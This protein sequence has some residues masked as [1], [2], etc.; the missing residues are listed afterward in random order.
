[1]G[2]LLRIEALIGSGHERRTW[3]SRHIT[4]GGL[5]SRGSCCRRSPFISHSVLFLLMR[6]EQLNT[7]L[8]ICTWIWEWEINFWLTFTPSLPTGFPLLSFCSLALLSN[9]LCPDVGTVFAA[10][11]WSFSASMSG[12]GVTVRG[13]KTPVSESTVSTQNKQLNWDIRIMKKNNRQSTCIFGHFPLW[14]R[15]LPRTASATKGWCR[16]SGH[17][18]RFWGSLVNKPLRKLCKGIKQRV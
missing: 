11:C 9:L 5:G 6:T 10:T 8:W 16:R 18:S 1:M 12:L 15:V 17:D 7:S 13:L 4:G 14:L 3:G 2:W